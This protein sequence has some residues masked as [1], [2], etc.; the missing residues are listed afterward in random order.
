MD[1][2][3]RSNQELEKVTTP[4]LRAFQLFSEANRANKRAQWAISA[5]LL[6]EAIAGDPGFASA[7]TWLA[8][9]LHNL[10]DSGWQLEIQRAMELSATVSERERYFIRASY[11]MLHSQPE[12]AI[13]ILEALVRV[14][15]DHYFG[16]TNLANAYSNARRNAEART[17]MARLADLRPNDYDA[18][19]R[20]AF[21]LIH[22][23]VDLAS[24]YAQR[25]RMLAAAEAPSPPPC[26]RGGDVVAI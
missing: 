20:A 16:N 8:W 22:F 15:P 21:A 26:G 24:K 12:A 7:H 14:Y 18:N 13:P 9:D 17:A 3:E 11:Y 19:A 1:R 23:D 25:A 10:K 5:Q 4:S 6:R 2:I